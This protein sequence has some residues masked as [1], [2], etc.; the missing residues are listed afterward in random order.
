MDFTSRGGKNTLFLSK[1]NEIQIYKKII[2]RDL[3]LSEV[4]YVD[5]A[6]FKN[7]SQILHHFL[8]NLARIDSY[9]GFKFIEHL[10]LS[11]KNIVL[12]N[13]E[14]GKANQNFITGLVQSQSNNAHTKGQGWF[15][16]IGDVEHMKKQTD[17]FRGRITY[18]PIEGGKIVPNMLDSW[19]RLPHYIKRL[20]FPKETL[21][22]DPLKLGYNM[23]V[24][25]HGAYDRPGD[26]KRN[27]VV[28]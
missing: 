24:H 16:L 8:P 2:E 10:L 23:F 6:L 12:Y 5:C 26:E 11:G 27:V 17:W 22:F 4:M 19:K 21:S 9:Y 20:E 28:A 13:Y 7:D 15:I 3:E 1:D 14:K 18:F 25:N